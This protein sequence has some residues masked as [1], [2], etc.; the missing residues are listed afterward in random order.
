M[1]DSLN[2]VIGTVGLIGV[3]A[4]LVFKAMGVFNSMY[5]ENAAGHSGR[6]SFVYRKAENEKSKQVHA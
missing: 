2:L 4:R 5:G 3:L 6:G 1:S